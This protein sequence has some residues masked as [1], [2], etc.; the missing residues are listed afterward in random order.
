MALDRPALIAPFNIGGWVPTTRVV[1]PGLPGDPGYVGE[2][3]SERTIEELA[4]GRR[5][6]RRRLAP[7]Q[8]RRA[9]RG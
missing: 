6:P 4:R 3:W 2:R 7:R 5:R 1:A 8:R 9:K